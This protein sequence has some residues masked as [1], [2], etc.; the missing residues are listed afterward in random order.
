MEREL[1]AFCAAEKTEE[2]KPVDAPATTVPLGVLTSS[3]AGVKGGIVDCESLLGMRADLD[4]RC[5]LEAPD[6]GASAS[7]VDVVRLW[8]VGSPTGKSSVS[9]LESVGVGGVT[10][11]AGPLNAFGGVAG[12][13]VTIDLRLV[14]SG[15]GV[16]WPGSWKRG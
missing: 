8:P 2:K 7:G 13:D 9:D 10:K 5:V 1:A 6:V 16:D 15:E 3:A 12:I 4:R 11:V 14:R